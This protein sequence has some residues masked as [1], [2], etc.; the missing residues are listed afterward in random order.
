VSAA[1]GGEARRTARGV[2]IGGRAGTRSWLSFRT[3]TGHF[4]VVVAAVG[5]ALS[6][7]SRD[8]E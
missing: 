3:M 4:L 1:R 6:T 7:P 2:G 8:G 5:F